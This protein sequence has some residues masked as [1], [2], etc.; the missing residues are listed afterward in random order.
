MGNPASATYGS[1]EEIYYA[2][3][4]VFEEKGGEGDIR[5]HSELEAGGDGPDPTGERFEEDKAHL[6]RRYP[7]LWQQFGVKWLG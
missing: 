1:H 5:D 3:G 2:A 6:A 4:E 7:K